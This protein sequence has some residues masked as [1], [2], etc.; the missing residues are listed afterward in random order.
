M[1]GADP[2]LAAVASVHGDIVVTLEEFDAQCRRKVPGRAIARLQE[3]KPD[4]SPR[5]AHGSCGV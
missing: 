2:F 1:R 3:V 4:R 5:T